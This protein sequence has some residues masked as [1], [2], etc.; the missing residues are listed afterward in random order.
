MM[1]ISIKNS[2][3]LNVLKNKEIDPNS[4]ML[5]SVLNSLKD[6]KQKSGISNDCKVS[7]NAQESYSQKGLIISI[8]I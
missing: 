5:Q 1:K 2:H 7:E 4:E 6:E 8:F 3:E